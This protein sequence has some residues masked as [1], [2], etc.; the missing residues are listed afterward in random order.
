M[1]NGSIQATRHSRFDGLSWLQGE[2]RPANPK[3]IT[4]F[5]DSV[6]VEPSPGISPN[7]YEYREYK[8]WRGIPEPRPCPFC[9]EARGEILK[10]RDGFQGVCPKC[11]ATGPKR[12]G[13]GDALRS[14]NGRRKAGS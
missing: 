6:P 7:G 10:A 12:V 5:L 8:N 14:R 9:K 1:L 3:P 13:Y 4:I 2:F 11:G